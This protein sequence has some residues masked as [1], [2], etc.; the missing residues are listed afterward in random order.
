MFLLQT[1]L[2]CNIII[3]FYIII[4]IIGHC[5]TAT[6]LDAARTRQ[7]RYIHVHAQPNKQRHSCQRPRNW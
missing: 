2:L 5:L 4:I 6:P 7:H 1:L 3:T